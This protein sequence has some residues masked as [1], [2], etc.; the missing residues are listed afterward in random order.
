MPFILGLSTCNTETIQLTKDRTYSY[1]VGHMLAS[2]ALEH[3]WAHMK[4]L[5]IITGKTAILS[6]TALKSPRFHSCKDH[7]LWKGQREGVCPLHYTQL[8]MFVNWIDISIILD[9][10][11]SLC[12]FILNLMMNFSDM[13]S[14][15]FM[16]VKLQDLIVT[17]YCKKVYV[18][19]TPSLQYQN[20]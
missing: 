19:L 12:L 17:N 10:H 14:I 5:G 2:T 3:R 8:G 11:L 13:T 4:P 6:F 1:S 9:L 7:L 16:R 18:M 20:E 15:F